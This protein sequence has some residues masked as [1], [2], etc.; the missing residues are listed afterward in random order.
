VCLPLR[1]DGLRIKLLL[2][3]LDLALQ[4]SLLCRQQQQYPLVLHFQLVDRGSGLVGGGS[5]GC[6][7]IP[8]CYKQ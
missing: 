4:G 2:E 8:F 3:V 7:G 1:G 5:G 6:C